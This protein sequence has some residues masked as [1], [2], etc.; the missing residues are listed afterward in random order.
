MLKELKEFKTLLKEKKAIE[1]KI[2]Q[3]L[4]QTVSVQKIIFHKIPKSHEVISNRIMEALNL[5]KCLWLKLSIYDSFLDGIHIFGWKKDIF[6]NLERITRMV[7]LR[8]ESMIGN[9]SISRDPNKSGLKN[10]I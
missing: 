3:F 2:K 8:Q 5:D 7:V 1:E 6:D 9:V 10:F 4:D